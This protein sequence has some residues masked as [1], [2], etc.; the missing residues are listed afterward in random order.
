MRVM[1]TGVL[2]L[3]FVLTAC[4]P[5]INQ[6]NAD[7]YYELGLQAEAARNWRSARQAYSRALAN[8]KSSGAPVAYVSAVTYNLG[9]MTGYTCNYDE[10]EQ[11]LLD[12]LALEEKVLPINASNMTKRWSELG[13]LNYDQ[14]KFKTAAIWYSKAI[15][16]L[17]RLGVSSS[18][19][20]GFARFIED[21]ADALDKAGDSSATLWR[22]RASTLRKANSS[23][24]ANFLPTYYRDVCLVKP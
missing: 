18:D 10:A 14:G 16:E 4:V 15:P 5:A 1:P 23:R 12:A 21:H 20:I 8:A 9:R 6:V 7:R 24:S 3:V 17:E 2:G 19:P 22:E 11:L 13:R